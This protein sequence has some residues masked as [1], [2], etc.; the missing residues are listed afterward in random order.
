MGSL[1]KSELLVQVAVGLSL[2]HFLLFLLVSVPWF[3]V[4]KERVPHKTAE[5]NDTSLMGSALLSLQ[6]Q[7]GLELKEGQI[8]TTV[9]SCF[10]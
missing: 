7:N 10:A 1:L 3:L 8:E 6:L 4:L 5:D 9:P 2:L